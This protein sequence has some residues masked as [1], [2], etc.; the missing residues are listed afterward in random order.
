MPIQIIDGFKIK[1]SIPVDDRL[2]KSGLNQRDSISYKYPGLRTFDLSDQ[3]PYVWIGS[4][5]QKESLD[6]VLFYSKSTVGWTQSIF[7]INTVTTSNLL[8]VWNKETNELI[9]SSIVESIY[10]SKSTLGLNFNGKLPDF[11]YTLDVNGDVTSQKLFGTGSNLTDLN[12]SN[13]LSGSLSANFIKPIVSEQ[14]LH[15]YNNQTKWVFS[16]SMTLDTI[17]VNLGTTGSILLAN[18]NLTT[19][20]KIYGTSSFIYDNGQILSLK[21]SSANTPCYSFYE[22]TNT[23]FYYNTGI[24][25]AVNGVDKLKIDN[26]GIKVPYKGSI[27][28]L[29][30]DSN[31]P[32]IYGSTDGKIAFEL[33]T[34]SGQSLGIY[35]DRINIKYIQSGIN[36]IKYT[37]IDD[38]KKFIFMTDDVNKLTL[39]NDECNIIYESASLYGNT[40]SINKQ[41]STSFNSS[42]DFLLSSLNTTKFN[43]TTSETFYP[44]YSF[45]AGTTYSTTL[46]EGSL[47][48][49]EIGNFGKTGELNLLKLEFD[50][51]TSSSG[52]FSTPQ[53]IR[54]GNMTSSSTISPGGIGINGIDSVRRINLACVVSKGDST[55]VFSYPP[56]FTSQVVDTGNPK[57]PGY[58]ITTTYNSLPNK[59][60]GG[61]TFSFSRGSV[62]Q[63]NNEWITGDWKNKCHSL[64]VNVPNPNSDKNRLFYSIYCNGEIGDKILDVCKILGKTTT[65]S[66]E[67]GTVIIHIPP[68]G[69]PYGWDDNIFSTDGITLTRRDMGVLLPPQQNYII[70]KLYTDIDYSIDFVVTFTNNNQ[71]I[72]TIDTGVTPISPV[73]FSGGGGKYYTIRFDTVPGMDISGKWKILVK[74]KRDTFKIKNVLNYNYTQSFDL[75]SYIKVT[76]M[77]SDGADRNAMTSFSLNTAVGDTNYGRSGI[78]KVGYIDYLPSRLPSTTYL[79][80]TSEGF[81][82]NVDFSDIDS[83]DNFTKAIL[84]GYY[85]KL[86]I[87]YNIALI[88]G[89]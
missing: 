5:W 50:K 66:S 42:N 26:K 63:S 29:D 14:I 43:A 83:Y 8:K 2:V 37:D 22:K 11:N 6:S 38:S 3:I 78:D 58:N 7:N 85:N 12:A 10:R 25:F 19:S 80:K 77:G 34:T 88:E 64:I 30:S 54:G 74:F 48:L 46:L 86:I 76:S 60:F 17:N 27:R 28:F 87:N 51:F 61:L 52:I 23:G 75:K 65:Y 72:K 13:I 16:S 59:A 79:T 84:L 68:T 89:T 70:F 39:N 40:F 67:P 69:P 53:S 81:K 1:D 24:I 33:S 21:D 45:N 32:V 31:W 56:T 9:N 35:K 47:N 36:S 44:S 73:E 18:S 20:N 41:L 55:D 15:T 62:D 82:I 57:A 4:K 49:N 71:I